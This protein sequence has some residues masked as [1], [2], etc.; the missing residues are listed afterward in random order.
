[1]NGV[2]TKPLLNLFLS[3]FLSF[4]IPFPFLSL[5]CSV[6]RP[7]PKKQG[8]FFPPGIGVQ[9]ARLLWHLAVYEEWGCCGTLRRTAAPWPHNK[10]PPFPTRFCC[11]CCFGGPRNAFFRELFGLWD[12]FFLALTV[13]PLYLMFSGFLVIASPYEDH[14]NAWAAPFAPRVSPWQEGRQVTFFP[15]CF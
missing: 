3:S 11:F 10:D 14:R 15:S 4:L 9:G 13:R 7:P 6:I 5:P 8:F 1:M 2:C 12:C